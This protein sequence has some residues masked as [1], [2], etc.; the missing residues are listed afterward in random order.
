MAPRCF[1]AGDLI[2]KLN[3]RIRFLHFLIFPTSR[4]AGLARWHACLKPPRRSS[5]SARASGP[6]KC[7]ASLKRALRVHLAGECCARRLGAQR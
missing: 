1:Q 6:P 5:K 2:E 7:D 4:P 3:A